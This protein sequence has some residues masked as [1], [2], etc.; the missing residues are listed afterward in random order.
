MPPQSPTS[1]STILKFQNKKCC[2]SW[3][4]SMSLFANIVSLHPAFLHA[5]DTSFATLIVWKLVAY[6]VL[7]W[8]F[9]CPHCQ[10]CPLNWT[11]MTI[12]SGLGCDSFWSPLYQR[13]CL[14]LNKQH[15]RSVC[16]LQQSDSSSQWWCHWRFGELQLC[17]LSWCLITVEWS[18]FKIHSSTV[19]APCY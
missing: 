13:S 18:V 3:I 16:Y 12:C 6:T 5:P 9:H 15:W 1:V 7:N 2:S 14:G 17:Q 4:C 11:E 8:S 10:L 19:F